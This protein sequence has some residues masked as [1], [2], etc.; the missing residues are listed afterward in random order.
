[1]KLP[2]LLLAA[3]QHLGHTAPEGK[4][5]GAVREHLGLLQVHLKGKEAVLYWKTWA[6]CRCSGRGELAASS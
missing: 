5:G 6:S 3:A 1:M 2:Q 4:A